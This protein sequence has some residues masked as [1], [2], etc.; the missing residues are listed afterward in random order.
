MKAPSVE[1]AARTLR[2]VHLEDQAHAELQAS[3]YVDLR[4]VRCRVHNRSLELHG[5]VTSFFLKQ[6]AQVMLLRLFQNELKIVNGLVVSSVRSRTKRR[7]VKL[8]TS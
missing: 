6:I 5:Q 1:I 7:T 3:S 8:G 2:D 4:Q